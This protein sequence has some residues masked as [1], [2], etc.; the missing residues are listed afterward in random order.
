MS[1]VDDGVA[2]M[3]IVASFSWRVFFTMVGGVYVMGGLIVYWTRMEGFGPSDASS[4]LT[5]A[6][7]L[8]CWLRTSLRVQGPTQ[9]PSQ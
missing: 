4:N 2:F 5:Q 9:I 7:L 3:M 1:G 8:C 6:T